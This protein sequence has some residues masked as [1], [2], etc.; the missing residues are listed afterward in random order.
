[1]SNT[2][3]VPNN[4]HKMDFNQN[5]YTVNYNLTSFINMDELILITE[6]YLCN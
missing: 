3:F 2:R 6:V 4:Y 5:A 1:M